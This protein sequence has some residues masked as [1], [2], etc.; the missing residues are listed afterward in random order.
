MYQKNN[1]C[2]QYTE[3]TLQRI[4]KNVVLSAPPAMVLTLPGSAIPPVWVVI[5]NP[6]QP[7]PGDR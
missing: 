4:G 3:G 1:V 2:R 6:L 7:V 5:Q